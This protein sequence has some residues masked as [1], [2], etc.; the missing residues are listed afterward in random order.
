MLRLFLLEFF[1][2]CFFICLLVVHRIPSVHQNSILLVQLGMRRVCHQSGV[3]SRF[4][5]VRQQQ[6]IRIVR[7]PSL[8]GRLPFLVYHELSKVII[9]VV[10]LHQIVPGEPIFWI[11]L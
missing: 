3:N 7:L 2:N 11:V 1:Q 10:V 8:F 6:I 9:Q 5:I 4:L